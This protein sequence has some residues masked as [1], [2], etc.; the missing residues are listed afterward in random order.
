MSEHREIALQEPEGD[1][2]PNPGLPAHVE[3]PTDVDEALGTRAERQVATLFGVATLLSVAFCVVY[4]AVEPDEFFL[5]MGLQNMLL[6]LTLGLALLFI[7]LP[8][9]IALV[10]MA[11]P[12]HDATRLA[13]RHDARVVAN[14]AWLEAPVPAQPVRRRAASAAS[15]PDQGERVP[16][17]IFETRSS[18][19]RG[20]HD[21]RGRASEPRRARVVPAAT[22]ESNPAARHVQ[23]P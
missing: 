8:V 23:S 10:L 9:L 3:R 15:R 11:T 12:L 18:V 5:G 14:R 13:P 19:R 21:P 6:G 17:V 16:D 4:F 20:P 2:I 1:P 22:V 7:G